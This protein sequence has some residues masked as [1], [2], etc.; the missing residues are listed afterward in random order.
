M[1]REI[2]IL[3]VEPAQTKE[4]EKMHADVV[5]VLRRQPGYHSDK[6]LAAREVSGQYVLM[7]E[8]ESV[9]AHQKFIDSNDY[10]LMSSPYGKFVKDSSFAH[11]TSVVES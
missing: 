3:M 6:L 5:S 11:Y 7:V 4:F 2:C 10:P 8:W 9:E 1:V